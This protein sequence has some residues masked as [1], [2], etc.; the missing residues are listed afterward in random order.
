M[1]WLWR[2]RW[3]TQRR[4]IV[5]GLISLLT[6]FLGVA[7]IWGALTIA[8]LDRGPLGMRSTNR[9]GGLTL[10]VRRPVSALINPKHQLSIFLGVATLATLTCGWLLGDLLHRGHLEHIEQQQTYGGAQWGP[11]AGGL[12]HSLRNPLNALYLTLYRLHRAP[13]IR[14]DVKLND[15]CEQIRKQLDRIDILLGEFLQFARP[16]TTPPVRIAA[17]DVVERVHR[18][19]EPE[20]RRRGIGVERQDSLPSPL[21]RID[22]HQFEQIVLNLL[23]NAQQVTP[24]GGRI[25]IRLSEQRG[26]MILDVIDQGPGIPESIRER[27][28][29]PFVTTRPGAAGLGLATVRRFARDHGGWAVLLST[30]ST[31]SCFR[32]VLPAYRSARRIGITLPYWAATV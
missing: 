4:A 26:W 2:F 21:V 3:S 20:M 1:R 18:F 10:P 12:S 15:L 32:V 7:T 25:S 24:E 22:V 16:E 27:L 30:G 31:G 28:F 8:D 13:A 14:S 5:S 11:T 23:L 29:E 6:L 17:L 19:L 9:A